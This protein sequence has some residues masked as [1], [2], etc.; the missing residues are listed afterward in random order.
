MVK[1]IGKIDPVIE[2]R[3][4]ANML[5]IEKEIM[6]GG[7]DMPRRDLDDMPETFEEDDEIE[8]DEEEQ[9]EV[10]EVKKPSMKKPELKKVSD[11][12]PEVQ[13]MEREI[14]LSL[15]NDKLNYVIS[16]LQQKG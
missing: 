4:N 13:V 6:K 3:L 7:T 11:K 8:D 10:E 9:E 12:K 16:L 2:A 15:I 1:R 5:A 14:N